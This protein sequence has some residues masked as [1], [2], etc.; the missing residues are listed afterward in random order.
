M[1]VRLVSQPP[2]GLGAGCYLAGQLGFG[3]AVWVSGKSGKGSSI[4]GVE[5][6]LE[7]KDIGALGVR[8]YCPTDYSN[9][10]GKKKMPVR[11]AV[12]LGATGGL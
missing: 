3:G 8:I 1:R 12:Q 2:A 7:N 9:I 5:L 11:P 10:G 4:L 6:L